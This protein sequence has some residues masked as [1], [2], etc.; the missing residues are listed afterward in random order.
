MAYWLFRQALSS[1]FEY[2]IQFAPRATCWPSWCQGRGSRVTPL[3]YIQPVSTSDE[4]MRRCSGA[5]QLLNSWFVVHRLNYLH[6]SFF[7]VDG[8]WTDFGNWSACSITCGYGGTRMRQ[9]ACSN[10]APQNDG[11]VCPGESVEVR[12]C[13]T[14]K[15][16]C[17]LYLDVHFR[18][19]FF[20]CCL[21]FNLTD[22]ICCVF[23][24][25][26]LWSFPKNLLLRLL[27]YIHNQVTSYIR[28]LYLCFECKCGYNIM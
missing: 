9:R 4:L 13:E 12:N 1:A 10:P 21:N 27:T 22:K 28:W 16:C 6:F 17:K 26:F 11:L 3:R 14:E 15:S 24:Q 25:R 19:V 5:L 18:T 20:F 23:P 8:H 7:L 2:F